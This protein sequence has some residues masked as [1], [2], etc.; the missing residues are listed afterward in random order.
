MRLTDL[1]RLEVAPILRWIESRGLPAIRLTSGAI[2]FPEQ[3]LEAWLAERSTS[4]RRED[5][6]GPRPAQS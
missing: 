1:E 2:R 6:E 3:E 5:T 4:R